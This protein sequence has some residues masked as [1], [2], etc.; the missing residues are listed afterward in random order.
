M[1]AR[2]NLQS[3]LVALYVQSLNEMID[4]HTRRAVAVLNSRLP[5]SLWLGIYGVAFLTM[6]LVGLQSSYGERQNWLSLVV[7]VLVFAVVLTL[8]VD[9]D[10]PLEGLLTVSQQA[11]LDLQTQLRALTP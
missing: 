11:L 2:A 9:L 3:P 5:S 1:V 8:I 6:V 4:I 10:R 7:L